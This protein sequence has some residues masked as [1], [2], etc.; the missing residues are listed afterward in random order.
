MIYPFILGLWNETR[1]DPDLIQFLD[2]DPEKRKILNYKYIFMFLI[3]EKLFF[4]NFS[5]TTQA[6]YFNIIIK[7]K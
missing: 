7:I 1:F 5:V 4:L 3:V 2:P 6:R